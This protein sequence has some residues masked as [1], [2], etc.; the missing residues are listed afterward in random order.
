MSTQALLQVDIPG[1]GRSWT[2]GSNAVP[3]GA[4]RWPC[5]AAARAGSR[6]GERSPFG[7]LPRPSDPLKCRACGEHDLPGAKDVLGELD[8]F[9]RGAATPIISLTEA[10]LPAPAE[11]LGIAWVVAGLLLSFRRSRAVRACQGYRLEC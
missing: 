4:R 6:A 11:A 8:E 3:Q 9:R 1:D 7:H 2:F 5:T 10:R